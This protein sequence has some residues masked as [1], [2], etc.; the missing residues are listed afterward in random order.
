MIFENGRYANMNPILEYKKKTKSISNT[1]KFALI[2]LN[3]I[4]CEI[5]ICEYK[6][7]TNRTQPTRIYN[8]GYAIYFAIFAP[9]CKRVVEGVGKSGAETPFEVW[10]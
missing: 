5:N 2:N 3:H 6:L 8:I 1:Q 9:W 7:I 4:L 10:R